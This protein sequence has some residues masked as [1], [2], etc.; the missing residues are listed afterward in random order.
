MAR[1]TKDFEDLLDVFLR[2][3]VR[4]LIVGAHALAHHAKPRYTKDLDILVEATPV[5]AARIVEALEKF[6]FGGLGISSSD[7]D[8]PA[9][10]LQLGVPPT[11]I[12]IMTSIDGISFPEAW[13]THV[14]GSYGRLDVPFIGYEALIRN[15]AA[16]AR[17]QDLADLE[18]LRRV[19]R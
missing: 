12:D 13:E 17:P 1:A 7:F 6:G 8:Q 3:D 15:K 2:N 5:N 18:I 16:S 19:R 9:R 11:R 10:I 4:F 14:V